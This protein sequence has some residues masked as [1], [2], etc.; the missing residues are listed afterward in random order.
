M[1]VSFC[2]ISAKAFFSWV[3]SF[4][5]LSISFSLFSVSLSS[6]SRVSLSLALSFFS[7]SSWSSSFVT[8]SLSSRALA[9]CC[10]VCVEC[11]RLNCFSLVLA[12]VSAL[13]W[14]S[15]SSSRIW[16]SYFTSLSSSQSSAFS[17]FR[18]FR[19]AES[20]F[21]VLPDVSPICRQQEMADSLLDIVPLVESDVNESVS[22]S[23]IPVSCSVTEV[24][25]S[26]SL[27]L[28]ESLGCVGIPLPLNFCDSSDSNF[29][30]C[31]ESMPSP[32][33][34]PEGKSIRSSSLVR[35]VLGVFFLWEELLQGGE[36]SRR[37][38][39]DGEKQSPAELKW[40]AA[41][42]GGG[43]ASWA[44]GKRRIKNI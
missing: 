21:S 11:F 30:M 37:R 5:S 26:V 42:A 4:W 16:S 12:S 19:G 43:A 7:R 39:M 8:L 10:S 29:P 3:P 35:P 17:F 24:S 6:A 40:G 9:R 22:I 44:T 27:S 25:T 1:Q 2:S 14:V 15:R 13:L 33:S 23:S 34:L 36:R 20:R 28:R 31:S 18:S 41:T 32:G 38:E